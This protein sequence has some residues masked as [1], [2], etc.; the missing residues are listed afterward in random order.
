MPDALVRVVLQGDEAVAGADRITQ[1]L[2]R[3]ERGEPTRALRSTRTAIDEL[4]ASASG[5]NPALA[6]VIANFAQMAVGGAPGLA[7]VGALSGAALAAAA[8]YRVWTADARDLEE[9][10]KKTMKA[11]EGF[12]AKVAGLGGEIRASLSGAGGAAPSYLRTLLG[13]FGIGSGGAHVGEGLNEQLVGQQAAVTSFA[14]QLTHQFGSVADAPTA[15]RTHLRELTDQ[16]VATAREIG[17]LNAAL[18]KLHRE[19]MDR[20]IERR[21]R[22]PLTALVEGTLPTLGATVRDIQ[23]GRVGPAAAAD[24]L[25]HGV[26]TTGGGGMGAAQGYIQGAETRYDPGAPDDPKR[27]KKPSDTHAQ[28]AIISS[29]LA[30]IASGRGGIGAGISALGGVSSA[31]GAL[32][33][34]A[35][36]HAGLASSL[37]IA[38][39]ALG[40]LGMLASLFSSGPPTVMIDGYSSRALSQQQQLLL[41]LTG[42]KGVNVQVLSAGG[43]TARIA[44]QLGRDARTDSQSRIPPGWSG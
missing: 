13:E 7:V 20:A 1:A 36:D 42:Y 40:G 14:A 37:G 22:P 6:R 8:S 39:V 2:G 4:A 25:L 27:G 5:L 17:V 34:L 33:S 3:M 21:E 44:Y 11:A 12:A 16:A 26:T 24:A 30:L 35:K 23:M 15:L 10:H 29:T 18:G 28:E 19:E 32:P 43:D 31:V 41:A 9:Q 38:G